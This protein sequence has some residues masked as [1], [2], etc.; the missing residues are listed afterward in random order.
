MKK[1]VLIF[2]ALTVALHA[3]VIEIGDG[4]AFQNMRDAAGQAVPG[5]TLLFYP[6]IYSG[7]QSVSSLKGLTFAWITITIATENSVIIRGGTNA[8][9]LACAAITGKTGISA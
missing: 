1:C 7:G 4:K 8:W 6:G 5:D 9:H 3:K 2:Y